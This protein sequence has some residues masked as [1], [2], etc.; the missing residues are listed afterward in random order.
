MTEEILA[1]FFYLN[2]RTVKHN[3]CRRYPSDVADPENVPVS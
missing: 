3:D 1:D 2:R